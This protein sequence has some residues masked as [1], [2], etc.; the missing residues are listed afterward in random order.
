MSRLVSSPHPAAAVESALGVAAL[1]VQI[2]FL[3]VVGCF[4][5]GFGNTFDGISF[6]AAIQC[7]TFQKVRGWNY[8]STMTTGN[9]RNF[10]EALFQSFC[11]ARDP[12][13]AEKARTYGAVSAAFLAGTVI[14]SLCA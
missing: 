5:K 4:P 1:T 2:L 13:A 14:G 7:S 12:D 9:L 11:G 3:F 6:V 8:G 10:A